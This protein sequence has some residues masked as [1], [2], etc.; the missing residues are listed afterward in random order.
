MS[1]QNGVPVMLLND[2]LLLAALNELSEAIVIYDENDKFVVCNEANR[3]LYPHLAPLYR[4]GVPLRD[5]LE[6]A[7][8]VGQW[9]VPEEDKDAF[10][11]KRLREH[12]LPRHEAEQHLDDGRWLLVRN[13]RMDNGL[14]IGMRADITHLKA[15]QAELESSRKEADAARESAVAAEKSKT[16]FLANMSHEIRTPMNG[17]MGMAELL[18]TTELDA[19]QKMFTDVIVKSGAALLTIIND[20]LDFSKIS[21]GQLELHPAPFNLAEAV[22]DVATLVSA[23]VREKDLELIVRVDPD[24]PSSLSGDVGRFRQVLTN[25][26]GN[27][28]KFTDKGHVLID[29]NGRNEHDDDGLAFCHL[30]IRVEDTGIGIP[31]DKLHAVFDKFSQVDASATRKFEGTGLGLSI[32]SSLVQLMGGEIAVE[33]EFGMG[34]TFSFDVK[35][36]LAGDSRKPKVVPT[37][38]SGS[39]VLIVD[40]NPVNRSI[41]LEQMGSWH[42]E[43]AACSDGASALAALRACA[44]ASMTVDVVILD[45]QMPG[46]SGEDVLREIRDQAP[47]RDLPVIMLTSVDNSKSGRTLK[48]LGA[49]AI[50][51]K[52]ARSSLLLETIVDV[53]SRARAGKPKQTLSFAEFIASNCGG[54]VAAP[55]LVPSLEEHR[56][57]ALER[58]E[59]PEDEPVT[60]AEIAGTIVPTRDTLREIPAPAEPGEAAAGPAP[61]RTPPTQRLDVLVAEDNEVNQMVV[62][63]ILESMGVSF[64]IVENG[65]LAVAKYRTAKP[66]VILM[67]V[68]MPEMNGREATAAIR[69]IEEQTGAHVP[70]ICLTA[71]AL[72]GDKEEFLALGMDDYL[73]KP[74]S[75]QAL[76]KVVGKWLE[77]SGLE[78]ALSAGR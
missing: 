63:Q 12:W 28:V 62:E 60:R 69:K 16:E 46:L 4:K 10:V 6:H 34:S 59:T 1:F 9:K 36:L 54:E 17:V 35:L 71:H 64:V 20:M 31:A 27:A 7:I 75:P 5:I 55:T 37:D 32:A 41:L 8:K 66:R 13:R 61:A 68:S 23:R 70:I 25:L 67:D 18:A 11:E 43:G 73:S 38:V 42:L 57:R 76:Q 45:Y 53:I 78:P 47:L 65:K 33:S 49:N 40:D 29:V 14:F 2:E 56:A 77:T 44:A 52:P 30:N 22:E 39:K 19:K 72:K 24:L 26:V 21:A 48:E 51:T 74:V 58:Q 50:L 15:R 3:S